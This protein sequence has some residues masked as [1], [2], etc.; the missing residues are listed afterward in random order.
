MKVTFNCPTHLVDQIKANA[1]GT[2]TQE[3]IDNIRLGQFV[4]KEIHIGTRLL[5]DRNGSLTVVTRN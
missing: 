3:F 2:L 4:N 1:K 5:L